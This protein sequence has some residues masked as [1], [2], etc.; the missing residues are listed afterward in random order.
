VA[1]FQYGYHQGAHVT[2]VPRGSGQIGPL[3]PNGG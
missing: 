1:A 3:P 2:R